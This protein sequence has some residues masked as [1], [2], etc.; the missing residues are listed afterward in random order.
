[1]WQYFL[2]RSFI[3]PI[4]LN[5]DSGEIAHS[6][7]SYSHTQKVKNT[8]QKY[9]TLSVRNGPETSNLSLGIAL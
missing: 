5:A 7:R 1:M 4:R 6:I 2:N 3:P 8:G 9:F